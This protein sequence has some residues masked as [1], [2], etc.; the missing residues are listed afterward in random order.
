MHFD[1]K[2]CRYYGDVVLHVHDARVTNMAIHI[3][4]SAVY[5]LI[6]YEQR[7]L[8]INLLINVLTF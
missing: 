8:L 3:F 6:T 1:V 5:V 7:F 2:Y 4:I